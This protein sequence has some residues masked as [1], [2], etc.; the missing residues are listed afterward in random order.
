M[1]WEKIQINLKTPGFYL[2]KCSSLSNERFIFTISLIIIL[3]SVG[4]GQYDEQPSI[5]HLI[6]APSSNSVWPQNNCK[7]NR[8]LLVPIAVGITIWHIPLLFFCLQIFFCFLSAL[9]VSSPTI[10]SDSK[11]SSFVYY[12]ILADI[13][14]FLYIQVG[15]AW[16]EWQEA[17]AF[18][19]QLILN[20]Q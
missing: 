5:I 19:M 18:R 15:A 3:N 17:S 9:I 4:H 10:V 1:Q 14:V 2:I 7:T 12:G 16:E 20:G 6:S 8:I 11:A 13:Y